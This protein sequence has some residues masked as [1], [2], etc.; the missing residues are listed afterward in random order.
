VL[1]LAL[2]GCGGGDTKG[3][4]GGSPSAS[5][6]V[7]TTPPAETN[8]VKVDAIDY[9]YTVSGTAKSGLTR[10]TFANT[11]KELHMLDM[12]KLKEGKTAADALAALKSD[13]GD[14]DEATFVDPDDSVDGQP[15]LLS[16]G[17]TTT[18]WTT[19]ESGTYALVCYVPAEG[20]G[21]SH[22]EKGMV[23]ALTVTADP[24][25][26][27][28]PQ[29]QGEITTDDKKLTVGDLTSGKGVYKY[30]N[31]GDTTH[32]LLLV[33]LNDGKTYADFIA[34]ADKFFEGGAK[35]AD[36][37]GELWG[38]LEATEK[39]AF[40]ELDLPPGKYLALDTETPENE[41]EEYFRDSQGG[42]RAEF[43][44]A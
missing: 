42:L 2:A 12:S 29:T 11:G 19:L 8:A 16:P 3:K 37:P 18:V 5:A 25:T 43:T 36:R 30:T 24:T 35:F 20:D 6:A 7:T 21:K 33:K 22:Y 31:S 41:D 39:T 38:G 40:L 28:E 17:A 44:V 26:A 13:A 27:P 9:G 1:G 23:N 32:A 14:D 15:S 4:A 34:W 10:I